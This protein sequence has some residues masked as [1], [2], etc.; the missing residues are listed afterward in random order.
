MFDGL[1]AE[2]AEFEDEMDMV[3][4]R[5]ERRESLPSKILLQ[6]YYKDSATFS[7]KVG[8]SSAS[9]AVSHMHLGEAMI[10]TRDHG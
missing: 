2:C 9:L 5:T 3:Q 7:A 6:C 4:T 1:V 10:R 8:M